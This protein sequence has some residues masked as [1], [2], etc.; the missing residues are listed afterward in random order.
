MIPILPE[1]LALDDTKNTAQGAQQTA[2]SGTL[3]DIIA[4]IATL[5]GL[6]HQ[7]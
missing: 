6:R 7:V 5:A 2:A 1:A 3:E 4:R